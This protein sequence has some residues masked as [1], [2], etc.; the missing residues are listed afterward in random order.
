M[1]A[2]AAREPGQENRGRLQQQLAAVVHRLA[3]VAAD[4]A[5]QLEHAAYERGRA[6]GYS[7]GRQDEAADLAEQWRTTASQVIAAA[8]PGSPQARTSVNRRIQAAITGGRQDAHEHWCGFHAKA[9]HWP[10]PEL[11][12]V[13]NHEHGPSGA[14]RAPEPIKAVAEH[15]DRPIRW[16]WQ[17]QPR[18]QQPSKPPAD[19]EASPE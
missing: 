7:A 11:L 18:P 9:Q 15:L 8:D 10:E 13:G 16:N 17:G 1:T 5:T 4:R 3:Q 12:S 19:R 14:R 2:P 6:A